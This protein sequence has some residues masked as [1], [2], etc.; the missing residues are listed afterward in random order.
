MITNL[1]AWAIDLDLSNMSVP[2][3]QVIRQNRN[4]QHKCMNERFSAQECHERLLCSGLRCSR[5]IKQFG[6]NRIITESAL[7][8]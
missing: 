5:T 4:L 6:S 3:I 1:R 8:R 7:L 2:S